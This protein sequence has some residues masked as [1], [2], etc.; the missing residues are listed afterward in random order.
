MVKIRLALAGLLAAAALHPVPALS[1]NSHQSPLHGSLPRGAHAV[2]FT[3][4]QLADTRPVKASGDDALSPAARARRIDVHIWYPAAP[5][6]TVE[7]MTLRRTA[8]LTA[9]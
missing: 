4:L 1:A 2:G 7:P 5:G 9:S 6:S 8:F 3:S